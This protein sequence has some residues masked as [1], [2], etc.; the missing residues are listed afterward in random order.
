MS[1]YFW[2]GIRESD[3]AD[4]NGIFIGSVTIFG[5]GAGEN[6]SMERDCRLRID[7]NGDAP[8]YD[9]Y[10]LR[11]MQNIM[12]QH[13]DA[14]FVQYD[15]LDRSALPEAFQERFVF[16]NKYGLLTRLNSKFHQKQI[17]KKLVPVLPF[18]VLPAGECTRAG[19][20]LRFPQVQRVVVQRDFSC[21]GSGTFLLPLDEVASSALPLPSDELCLVTAFEERNISVNIHCVIYSDDYLLFAPSIQIVRQDGPRLEYLGSDYSAYQTLPSAE[22]EQVCTL[23]GTLCRYLQQEGY[24]G[25][26][27]IDMLLSGGNCYLMEINPRFQAS[28]AILNSSHARQGFPSLQEYHQNAFFHPVCTLPRP[29]QAANGSFL[30]L[31]Y[32]KEDE[33]RLRWLWRAAGASASFVRCDDALC[34]DRPMEDGCYAFQIRSEQPLSSVTLQHSLRLH[35]NVNLSRFDLNSTVSYENLLKLKLLL[36]TRGVSITKAA[37]RSA[38]DR[39]GVDWEEFCA[40]TM[41]LSGDVWITAPCMESWQ[42]LSPLQIDAEPESGAFFLR[43]YGTR[44][45]PV[46][47]MPEDPRSSRK[48][49]AGHGHFYRDIAYLNP[50]R[51]RVYH[52]DGCVYQSCGMGCRFCDLFGS[53]SAISF[54]EIREVLDAYADE[55]RISHFLIGG[56]SGPPEEEYASI[57]RIAEYLHIRSGKHIY[58]MSQPIH[59]R[60]ALISLRSQG[61]TEVA[62]NIEVFDEAIARQ[63]MPGKSRHTRRDY[64]ECLQA[65]AEVFGTDGQVRSAVLVGFD[66]LDAFRTGIRQICE[67]GAVPMLSLFRP[68]ADTPLEHFMP[69]N[70]TEALVFYQTAKE[71]CD[72]FSVRL[73]PSCRACQNN[74]LALD[75]DP[76]TLS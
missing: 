32:H 16:Q 21:G 55:P 61:V 54:S 62:F 67:T 37:W 45:M 26:C 76:E 10:F 39:G 6:R 42:E 27:G 15:A 12:E 11:E 29:P 41:R 70:E 40:V 52:R 22:R 38:Q 20:N 3:I 59:G 24:L 65:A 25:V 53:G 9:A 23:A 5:S 51:L 2:L 31:H 13:P 43:Y 48:T 56:G 75:L 68:G 33:T 36:L 8:F 58:V 18:S 34:W 4:T 28:S 7:H 44:L 30:T 60:E 73:G 46:E 49:Q 14:R 1:K 63:L 17:L 74:V 69:V 19:L 66:A 64:L 35:P 72:A 50:D 47:I 57:R 71:I